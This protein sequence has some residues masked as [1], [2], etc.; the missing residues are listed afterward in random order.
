MVLRTSSAGRLAQPGIYDRCLANSRDRCG[1]VKKLPR[2]QMVKQRLQSPALLT[3]AWQ[4]SVFYGS[5]ALGISN[6]IYRIDTRR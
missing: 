1:A 4:I 2:R 5:S 6:Y 3:L